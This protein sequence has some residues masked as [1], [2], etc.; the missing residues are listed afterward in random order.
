MPLKVDIDG[1]EIW[2]EPT[3]NWKM[4]VLDKQ[5]TNLKVDPNFYGAEVNLQGS[6]K[7]GPVE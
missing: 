6:S 3:T 5:G 4:K 2:L 7:F 1:E